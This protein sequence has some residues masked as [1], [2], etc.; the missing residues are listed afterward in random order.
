[1]VQPYKAELLP[2]WRFKTPEIAEKSAYKIYGMFL[3]YLEEDDFVG[4]DMTR[5]FL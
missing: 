2:Y 3:A 1:L 5:K 4:A